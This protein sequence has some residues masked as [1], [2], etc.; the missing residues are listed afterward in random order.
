MH[1]RKFLAVAGAT[2]LTSTTGC[3]GS[4]LGGST[5][6][7][8]DKPEDQPVRSA[9][10]PYPAYGQ[11]LPEVSLDAPLA[12]RTISTTEFDDRLV[13]MT[14]IYSHCNSICPFLISTLRQVQTAATQNGYA[15]D[16]VFLPVTFD[17]ARDDEARLREYADMM[18]VDLGAGNWHF[19]RPRDHDHAKAVVEDTFG[20][21]FQ[22]T[23]ATD[24]SMYMYNHLGLAL[25]ANGDGVV[26]RAYTGTDPKAEQMKADVESI[27]DAR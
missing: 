14:F 23:G 24:S 1:R 18:H 8:L 25:L 4:V 2:A 20:V 13:L 6:T 17:P 5:K 3:V 26:E 22:K 12:G 16:V 27:L 7:V 10:L 11:S 19:L 21:T 9:N 15:D